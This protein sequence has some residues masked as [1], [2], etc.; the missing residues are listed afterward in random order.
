MIWR[1][2][3]D[4]LMFRKSSGAEPNLNLKVMH[5]INKISIFMFLFAILVMFIRFCR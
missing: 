5:G 4:Y 2:I 3:L 1:K